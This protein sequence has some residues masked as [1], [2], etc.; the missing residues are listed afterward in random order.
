M[1]FTHYHFLRKEQH[2]KLQTLETKRHFVSGK[3]VVGIDPAKNKHQAMVLDSAGVPLGKSFSFTNSYNGFHFKDLSFVANPENTAFA[4]ETSINFWQKICHYLS[5]KGYTVLLVRPITTKH[6]RPRLNNF[7]RTDPKDALCIASSARQ[8][9]FNFYQIY[10]DEVLALKR[11]AI[12]YDKLKKQIVIAKQRLRSEVEMLFPEFPDVIKIDTDTARYLLSNY[13]TAK[14]FSG[15]NLFSEAINLV[16]ISRNHHGA[17]TLK[18]LK[19]AAAKSIGLP[20]DPASYSAHRMS[21]NMWLEQIDMLKI[22]QYAVLKQMSDLAQKTPHYKILTSIKGVSDITASRFIAEI[23]RL[24]QDLHFKQV[25]AFAGLNLRVADSGTYKGHR[26]ITH[27]G[28]H[29]L[30]AILYKMT[31]EAKNH[32]PEVRIRFLKRQIK[33]AKYTQTITACTSNLLRLIMALLRE[34]R[35]YRFDPERVREME[36]LDQEYQQLKLKRKSKAA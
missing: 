6:E 33:S 8:G 1:V 27:W 12:T 32:V 25:E 13:L 29:R 34:Q 4:V 31:E 3:F 30:R 15:L 18:A 16:A 26:R 35:T 19:E 24:D 17:S 36:A 9:Y 2:M 5:E 11:L 28:N 20:L 23:P 14:D 22:Q 21:V 7:S 10:P